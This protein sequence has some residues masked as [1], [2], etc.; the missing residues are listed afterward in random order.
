[1]FSPD[2]PCFS[3]VFYVFPWF[4]LFSVVFYVSPDFPC[5]PMFFYGFSWFYLFFLVFL[6]FPLIVP[7]FPWFSMFSPDSPCFL[8]VFP[9]FSGFAM[10]FLESP[11]L[12]VFFYVFPCFPMFFY[13]FPS[14]CFPVFF[15]VFPCF[16]MFFYV[17]PW[18][19]LFSRVF[20]CF[21]MILP[22]FWCFSPFS[23][24]SPCFPMFF[25]VF[26]CFPLILS[27]FLVPKKVCKSF[28]SC[29]VFVMWLVFLFCNKIVNWT[30]VHKPFRHL[31]NKKAACQFS[32]QGWRGLPYDHFSLVKNIV[33]PIRRRERWFFT[34][35]ISSFVWL[36]C[37][38]KNRTIFSSL[39]S[40]W[41]NLSTYKINCFTGCIF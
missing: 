34:S 4:S 25:P 21:T 8:V 26:Q 28:T 18:F 35:E 38:T 3:V 23:P 30:D 13:V 24:V 20:L 17:F 12:P 5:F 36:I 33:R 32:R 9:D 16:P 15:Y 10:F 41:I 19:S 39:S 2:S 40:V 22:V 14:A 27:S 1:M 37:A 11:C 6:C 31:E 29:C 7:V